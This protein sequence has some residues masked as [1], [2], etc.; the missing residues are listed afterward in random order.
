[1]TEFNYDI[2][3]NEYGKQLAVS[4][5]YDERIVSEMKRL[6][7]ENTHRSWS[8]E[9]QAWLIDYTEQALDLFERQFNVVIPPQYTPDEGYQG[10]IRAVVPEDYTWFFLRSPPTEID[11]LLHQQLAYFND[12]YREQDQQWIRLYNR[13]NHGGPVGLLERARDLIESAG[14]DFHVDW[15]GDRRG[16]PVDLDWQF[17]HELRDYQSEAVAAVKE[18]GGGVVGLPTGTGKTVTAMRILYDL[19]MEFGRGIVLV[20]TQELLYQW[21]DELKESLNCDVGII[22]DGNWSEGDVTVAI[23]QTL[24]SRGVDNLEYDYGITVFDECHRTSAADTMHEVGMELD[25]AMR[26]GLSA[27]PWRRIDGEE[28]KIEGAVGNDAYSVTAARMIDEGYL[29]EP[30][31][32][33]A[34]PSD[35]GTLTPPSSN[36]PYH[37]AYRRCISFG[38]TRNRAVAEQAAEL[39]ADGY[40]VLIN[41]DRIKHGRILEHALNADVDSADII[42]EL[43]FDSPSEQQQFAST[44]QQLGQ[45]A[46][47][48]AEFMH[49]ADSTSIRQE[50]LDEFENG[51]MNILISTLLREGVDI[52]NINAIVLA[53]A[54]KSDVKQIQVIGR[55]LR[56][57]NGEHAKIVDFRDVGRYFGDQ[58][59]HR[60][61]S[62]RQYYGK[63]GPNLEAFGLNESDLET[64]DT[65]DLTSD[66]PESFDELMED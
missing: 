58:F 48:D 16:D 41:V 13:E 54:G 21:Q 1:M 27:T 55:A 8:D 4:F 19:A 7:W 25:T 22:G 44:L 2:V 51:D 36:E 42:D 40:K 3:E 5:D 65:E 23:M 64:D 53:Q 33:I 52:P 31:F 11:D 30:Q 60:V 26:V 34:E 24:V 46:D 20:H 10:E 14:Y 39:A 45:I 38:A 6:S 17:G 28:L 12:A 50:T 43:D 15:E 9:H 35:Y 18:N 32:E 56:P 63:Y 37:D 59:E 62:M 61:M 47:T 29:A 66:P 49:G 57:S